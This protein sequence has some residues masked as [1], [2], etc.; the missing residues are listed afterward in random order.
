MPKVERGRPRGGRSATPLRDVLIAHWHHKMARWRIDGHLYPH[1]QAL[2]S[3]GDVVVDS[4]RL[5]DALEHAGKDAGRFTY[6]GADAGRVWLLG[7]D[8]PLSLIEDRHVADMAQADFDELVD[9]T[10]PLRYRVGD[11]YD[12]GAAMAGHT[13]WTAE[14]RA[15]I[16]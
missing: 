16:G 8:D 7:A 9:V 1:E 12:P 10:G 6:A 3:D 4:A 13:V 2:R 15:A 5:A 11:S 14:I